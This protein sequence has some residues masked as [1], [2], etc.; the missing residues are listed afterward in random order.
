MRMIKPEK[1]IY[2]Y[3]QGSWRRYR[4]SADLLAM[5]CLGDVICGLDDDVAEVRASSHLYSN[6]T[7]TAH[8]VAVRRPDA[9]IWRELE[10]IRA[11]LREDRAGNG[12]WIE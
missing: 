12:E 10:G 2:V 3:H 9:A 11:A 1:P 4:W 8:I 6:P 5:T 7:A